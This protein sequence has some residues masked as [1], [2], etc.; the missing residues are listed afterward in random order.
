MP[1]SCRPA[2][3]PTPTPKKVWDDAMGEVGWY[4]GHGVA[5]RS[6]DP[7]PSSATH[8]DSLLR[9]RSG[10][11]IVPR[12]PIESADGDQPHPSPISRTVRLCG[13]KTRS[14]RPANPSLSVQYYTLPN[15]ALSPLHR[16]RSPE[17]PSPLGVVAMQDKSVL[18]NVVKVYIKWRTTWPAPIASPPPSS[19]RIARMMAR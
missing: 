7:S 2:T 14:D 13:D 10:A 19:I 5:G 8:P 16:G 15:E 3:S 9:R 1:S 11:I 4:R 12:T 17:Q 6:V 18:C